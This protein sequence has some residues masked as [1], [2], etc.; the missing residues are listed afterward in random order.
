LAQCPCWRAGLPG[1][2]GRAALVRRVGP[3]PLQ[4]P[5]TP[6]GLDWPSPRAW[7]S[8]VRPSGGLA[9]GRGSGWWHRIGLGGAGGPA[10]GG[11]R[12]GGADGAR[13]HLIPS[14]PPLAQRPTAMPAQALPTG[15]YYADV[16]TPRSSPSVPRTGAA[17]RPLTCLEL[18][19]AAVLFRACSRSMAGA[20]SRRRSSP[21]RF[22]CIA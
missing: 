10:G 4:R 8:S 16:G 7:R 13:P 3:A 22:L 14:H 12:P 5:G 21:A 18:K 1:G 2:V 20:A 19:L 9:E 6:R 11:R 17:Y 15:P